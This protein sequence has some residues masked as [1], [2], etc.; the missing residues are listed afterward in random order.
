MKEEILENKWGW[1]LLRFDNEY[2]KANTAA[3]QRMLDAG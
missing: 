2:S 3:W 1:A